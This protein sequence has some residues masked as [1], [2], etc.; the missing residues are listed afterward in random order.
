PKLAQPPLPKLSRAV[1]AVEKPAATQSQ[2]WVVG[3]HFKA[4][5]PDAVPLRVANMT[6]GGLFTSRLMTNLRETNGYSYG[7]YSRLSLMRNAGTFSA[8]GGILAKNTVDAV[9][10][11][12]KELTR[13]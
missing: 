9:S 2:V 1:D 12:E 6:L 8:A 13:F 10:E 5:E 3:C 11:Y 7:V 4:S